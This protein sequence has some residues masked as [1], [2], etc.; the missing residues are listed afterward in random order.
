MET[1]YLNLPN[2]YFLAKK[3]YASLTRRLQK[4]KCL[5][6][7]YTNTI[8]S[9]IEKGF[10]RKAIV[11]DP[12][13]D[14][15]WYL[16]HHPV[17]HP[18]KK[19]KMRVVF[20]AA[21]KYQG[22][23][24]NDQLHKG[25]DLLN[26]LAGV[27]IRFRE[28]RYT[29]V[30]DIEAMFHQI[31]L[32]SSDS[33]YMRFL[34]NPDPNK[35][36][37]VFEMLVHIFGARDSPCCANFALQKAARDN[38]SEF[39]K[40][41]IDNIFRNFYVDDLLKSCRTTGE[42]RSLAKE[43]VD[44]LKISGFRLTKFS[45]NSDEILDSLPSTEVSSSPSSIQFNPESF[46][47][48]LGIR[49]DIRSDEFSFATIQRKGEATKRNVL[50]IL[51]SVFDPLGLLNPFTLTI[52][53]LLQSLWKHKLDWD[54]EIPDF[55]KQIWYSWLKELAYI[56][57]FKMAR[58]YTTENSDVTDY[59]LHV[60]SDASEDAYATAAYLR[61]EHESG[62]VSCSLVMSK[63]RLA[64]LKVITIP[65]LELQAAV[66]SSRLKTS[67]TKE[68]DID[69]N[70]IY[71]WTD[72]MITLQYINNE[73]RRFKTFVANRVS[74]IHRS[75]SATDW[76]FVEGTENPADDATR[77][78]ALEEL[79]EC[80]RWFQGPGFLYNDKETWSSHI[81]VDELD[82]CEE[83]RKSVLATAVKF[84]EDFPIS[85]EKYSSWI[86][87]L[88]V[89]AWCFKFI[90]NCRNRL[91]L[92]SQ[93]SQYLLSSRDINQAKTALVR[94]VQK[95]EFSEE[96]RALSLNDDIPKKSSIANLNPFLDLKKVIRVGGRLKHASIPYSAK[97]QIILP[98]KHHLSDLFIRDEHQRNAHA[99]GEYVL[100]S[101]RQSLWIVG[102][103]SRIKSI[104][105][106]CLLCKMSRLKPAPTIM[107]DLPPCRVTASSPPFFHTGV[108]FFDPLLVKVLRSKAKRWGCIFTCMSTRA[109]HLEVAESLS[110]D[111][112][113]DVLRR[114]TSRRGQPQHLYSDCGTNFKGADK[115]L[116]E[117]LKELNQT[118]ISNWAQSKG[119]SWKFNPPEAPHMG[120][121]WE[122]MI[123]TVK[124]A[125]KAILRDQ[126]VNDFHLM[127]VF[128]EAEAI[129]NSR[130]LT[131]V[132]DDIDDLEALTPNHFLLSRATPCL[133]ISNVYDGDSC[134]RKRWRYVQW[135][136]DHFWRRW[137]R[138]YLPE[139]TRRNKW[140]RKSKSLK[141]GDL[142][143]IK[144]T[145][146]P[147]GSW[148]M[149]RVVEAIESEDGEVRIVKIKTS[150][151]EYTRPTAKLCLLEEEEEEKDAE[152]ETNI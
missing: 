114:F 52:K 113:I 55:A 109:T 103:R 105:R 81:E 24:L 26:S 152:E 36:P 94:H 21:V 47:R 17:F 135:L 49:W 121:A 1:R 111:S 41:T 83:I 32:A 67:L 144:D 106:Q 72:S 150:E 93:A 122:R 35:T 115:E 119:I 37:E 50:R 126:I 28:H 73:K 127:T 33:K 89:T 116:T 46:E 68:F 61:Q 101:I 107:A 14:E 112:F 102:C 66:L 123:R 51:S 88:R 148:S 134:H 129:V 62:V 19:D 9:Y 12:A 15:T 18:K 59:Q 151:G 38:S 74:E 91:T 100:S 86:R 142:V 71:F 60:F 78:M 98:K 70:A 132:S 141:V 137:K 143:P 77:G 58:C 110:T 108:D 11:S 25:P 75:S 34:W 79:I 54:D 10:A 31:F 45:S 40:I 27:L 65:R 43:L 5:H 63:N 56:D 23:S 139:L 120:G 20:D 92:R 4:D 133:P 2:N 64:P 8:N 48:A 125:L 82:E 87:L 117:C 69:I 146:C 44:L 80:K 6:E 29:I 76:R 7:K 104:I 124:T 99:G 16:P 131:A 136:A 39:C 3:R 84:S 57:K 147:R 30:A 90:R 42:G 53:K 128:T 145:N 96:Y 95:S 97:H 138:E 13:K 85:I 118:Q 149:A 22:N 140:Q 130:P